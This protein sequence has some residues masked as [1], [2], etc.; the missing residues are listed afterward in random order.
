AL[1]APTPNKFVIEFSTESYWHIDNFAYTYILP[2]HIFENFSP[3]DWE[4]W[5]LVTTAEGNSLNCGP[6]M[7]TDFEERDWFE[8]SARNPWSE[9]GLYGAYVAQVTPSNDV[10]T[11]VP[12][13]TLHWDLYWVTMWADNS[14]LDEAND[15]TTFS[16][17]YASFSYTIM[18][19][20]EFYLS[21]TWSDD[22]F[23]TH[24]IDVSIFDSYLEPGQHNVTLLLETQY[25][26]IQ[27][28]TVVV[29]INLPSS[30]I[31][32]VIGFPIPAVVFG[33]YLYR[34]RFRDRKHPIAVEE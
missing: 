1:Y 34:V 18:L 10:Q 13:F 11:I 12:Y 19:D 26:P 7:L 20:G 31:T 33:V 25:R 17:D 2:K 3:E 6:F 9:P 24:S 21:D 32:F 4:D 23:V 28:D 15:S 27:I 30:I 16:L 5:G 29:T 22:C 14:N 8:L